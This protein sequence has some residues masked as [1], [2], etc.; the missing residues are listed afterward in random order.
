MRRTLKTA[1][2]FQL[3]G[4]EEKEAEVLVRYFVHRGCQATYERPGE[5]DS[6]EIEAMHL[7]D[8]DKPI[9]ITWMLDRGFYGEQDFAEECGQDYAEHL[10][11]AADYRDELRREQSMESR[12]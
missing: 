1:L 9:D 7:I 2:L 11:E 12:A 10:A 8:G 5:N 4:Q 3:A 6:F